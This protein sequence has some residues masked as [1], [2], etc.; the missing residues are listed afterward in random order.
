VVSVG[1]VVVSVGRV[2]VSVG[3]VVVSVGVVV[4]GVVAAGVVSVMIVSVVDVVLGVVVVALGVVLVRGV[5]GQVDSRGVALAVAVAATIAG[6]TLVDNSGIEHADPI[7][8]LELVLLTTA[9]AYLPLALRLRGRAAVRAE[10]R[11]RI[12]AAGLC[13]F[14]AYV[15]VLAALTFAPAAPVA[16]VRETSIVIATALAAVFLGERVTRRRM[17]GAVVVAAGIAVL[18]LA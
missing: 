11:P 5:R 13:M 8:Y 14:G 1:S 12:L 2:V 4:V 6:Y 17:A 7:A 16:A 10:L 3:T 9:A 15:V 18:S